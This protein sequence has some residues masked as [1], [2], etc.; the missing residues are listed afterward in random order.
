[1]KIINSSSPDRKPLDRSVFLDLEIL[2]LLEE[3]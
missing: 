1:M 2:R 3:I